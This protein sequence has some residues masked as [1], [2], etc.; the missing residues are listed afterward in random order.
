MSSRF[1]L[2][3]A[4]A[5][6]CLLS[7]LLQPV[8]A[9]TAASTAQPKKPAATAATKTRTATAGAVDPLAAERRANAI[10]LVNAL[11]DESR[12]FRDQTLKAR[13]QMQAGDA[14]WETDKERARALFRRAWDS[15]ETADTENMRRGEEQN[16]AA[17]RLGTRGLNLPNLRGEVLRLAAKRERV[18]GEEFLARMEEARKRETSE[19][20]NASANL[21]TG[22]PAAAASA[23][24]NAAGG[25][26]AQPERRDPE[27]TPP[28]VARR[29]QLAMQFLTDGDVERALQFADPVLNSVNP[30]SVEFLVQLREKSAAE[31]D[32]RYSAL[33]TSVARAPTSDAGDILLLSSYVLTPGLY[34]TVGQGGQGIS[35]SQRRGDITAP[36]LPA[37]LRVAFA[38]A[39]SQ[40]LLRPLPQA[41]QDASATGRV[42]MFFVISRLM[43]FFEQVIPDGVPALRARLAALN[44]DIPERARDSF[45]DDLKRGLVPEGAQGDPVQESLDKA[46]RATDP[47]ERDMAYLRAA[48]AAASKGE[49]RARDFADK[50]ED[51]ELRRQTRAFI[52]F[53][54]V[55]RAIRDKKD[56][57]EVLRLLAASGELTPVQRAWAYTEAARLLAKDD[58]TR[59]LEALESAATAAKGIDAA[60]P[61]RV[62]STVAVATRFFDFDRN[63]AWE[64]M[65]DA[66]KAA[67]A[68]PEFTGADAGL[69]SRIRSGGM[70]MTMN[71]S[72]PVFDLTGVFQTLAREDMNRAVALAQTFTNE[73]PRAVAT[74]AVARAVLDGD[75]LKP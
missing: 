29:I 45:D 68:A 57:A 53:A 49:E 64:I 2:Q 39:A 41:D 11:A 62:R 47:R 50:I 8:H 63:R 71:F 67:N 19:L 32:R 65:A 7:L 43:P 72:A 20:N 23:T 33:L 34:M 16:R 5:V 30:L 60:D 25:K 26:Q 31:A 21:P 38:R 44:P 42:G 69:S 48:Q 66:V 18:L 6:V 70:S 54:L 4:A 13:V 46:G 24:P 58:R 9:Q 73:S 27:Q 37:A 75:K 52:D 40:V 36:E 14:L 3:D 51:S 17:G 35:S 59:A 28:D 55:N 10:A 15:A 74:L 22:A 61:D 56:G 12:G 1:R